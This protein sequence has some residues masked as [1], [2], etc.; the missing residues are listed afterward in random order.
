MSNASVGERA[1]S[2]CGEGRKGWLEYQKITKTGKTA[3]W[4]RTPM[5]A[6]ER[7]S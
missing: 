2:L 4:A 1:P 6:C 5:A 3:W 7:T